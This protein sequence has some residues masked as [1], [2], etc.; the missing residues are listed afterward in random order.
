MSSAM[1]STSWTG[2]WWRC[3]LSSEEGDHAAAYAQDG[4]GG[5]TMGSMG[6]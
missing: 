3:R 4:G 2:A 1:A 5:G 6:A